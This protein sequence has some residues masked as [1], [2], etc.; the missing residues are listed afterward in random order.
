MAKKQKEFKVFS[1]RQPIYK[2]F[3]ATIMR[4]IFKRPTIINLAGE[5]AD[6]S[7]VV[8]NHSAKSGPPCL[9]L[10]F[11]KKTAKWGA[12]EMFENYGSRK[13]YLRDILYIKKC[14]KKPGFK[15]SLISSI[16]AVFNP[17]VYKG[18]WMLPTYPDG[19]LMK[20]LRYSSMVLDANIPVMVFPENSN[21]GYKDVLTEFFPGFV[22]LAEKYFRATGEDLPVYPTYFSIKKHILV[23]GKPIFV[24]DLVKEGLT[25][26]E[27][28][29][30]YCDAVN[31]LYFEYVAEKEE[32]PQEEQ[33]EEKP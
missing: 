2:P 31:A 11:P 3:R 15:T 6:K 13:A 28:A 22:M 19:R 8:A 16:L 33:T 29:Q 20:T 17:M 12:H 4:L 9:D 30:K 5:I 27:I 14:G 21:N 32:K 26:E 24:Q 25:R 1:R 23:I 18:M 7:I 10:Y